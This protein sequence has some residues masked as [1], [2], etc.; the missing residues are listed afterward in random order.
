MDLL[1]HILVFCSSVLALAAAK[2][3]Y[4]VHF[5]PAAAYPGPLRARATRL[6]YMYYRMSGRLEFKIKELHDRYGRVVRVAPDE[7]SYNGGTA[8]DD[9]YGLRSKRRQG[10]NL[11]KDPHFYMGA[12]APNGQKNLGAA[13]DADHSRIRS[14]LSHAFSDRAIQNQHATIKEHVDRLI[15]RLR[16]TEGIA[17]DAVRW[18]HHLT[19]DVIVHLALGQRARSL[20]C[21][22]WHPQAR[23]VF[24][25]IREGVCL[26]EVLRFM[27]AKRLVLKLLLLLFG[28]ARRRNFEASVA[29]ATLRVEADAGDERDFMS[30][31]LRANETGREM[32]ASEITTNSALF[33]DA[34]SETTASMLSGCLFYLLKNPAS[35]EKLTTT[36]R[37]TYAAEDDM[38][39]TSLAQIPYVNAV[40]DE[41][42]RMF[43]P[44]PASLPRVTPAPDV[45]STPPTPAQVCGERVPAGIIVGV[46]QYAAYRSADNFKQPYSFVPERWLG[47]ERFADDHRAVVQPFST[48]P[49]NCIG[50]NLARAEIRLALARIVWT[51]DLELM[52]ECRNWHDEMKTWFVWYKSNL[53]ISF[54][55]RDGGHLRAGAGSAPPSPACS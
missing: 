52:P 53:Q 43:M 46:N 38:T 14:V 19:Y 22:G 31:I 10:P 16:E 29:K 50:K 4:N 12:E 49:R 33:I 13:N 18:M 30:Y 23:A 1:L 37:N 9:I 21:D 34:G 36:I 51:F 35:L 25:G 7:L 5:H 24:E 42:L 45:V 20:D 47:D 27:P 54:K 44:V 48:G 8:W 6:Y 32:T 2:I 3:L 17:T 28:R 11:A 15:A 55:P 26:I 40:I 41:S 39:P